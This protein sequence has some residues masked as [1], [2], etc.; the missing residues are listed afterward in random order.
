MTWFDGTIYNKWVVVV[1]SSI[2]LG[3]PETSCWKWRTNARNYYQHQDLF[4]YEL[5]W[6]N[7]IQ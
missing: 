4:S 5:V 1:L 3:Q 6:W 7:N 2:R